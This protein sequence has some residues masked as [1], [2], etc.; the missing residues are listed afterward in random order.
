MEILRKYFILFLMTSVSIC[1]FLSL[2]Y[3]FSSRSYSNYVLE[4]NPMKFVPIYFN[5]FDES[6]KISVSFSKDVEIL[7]CKS[8]NSLTV[9]VIVENRSD[10]ILSSGSEQREGPGKPVNIGYRLYLENN[11]MLF[12]GPRTHL[13]KALHGHS[14]QTVPLTLSCPKMGSYLLSIE[15]VQEGMAWQSDLSQKGFVNMTKLVSL[16]NFVKK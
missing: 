4:E 2:F 10:K 13:P 14:R 9:E 6:G 3:V 12:E 15:L 1:L 16:S 8:G 11:Q 7:T 5:I